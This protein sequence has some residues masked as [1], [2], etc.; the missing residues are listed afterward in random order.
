VKIA[1]VVL[2]FTQLMNLILVP[3]LAHAGLALS[4]G[5]G[6]LLNAAWLLIGL[7]RKGSFKPQPGWLKFGLR[8]VMA[9]LLLAIFLYLASQQLNWLVM[10]QQAVWRLGAMTLVMAFSVLIYFGTLWVSGLRLQSFLR[11]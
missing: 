9:T 1:I 5:L 4:I 11:R 8:V 10:R 7:L 2:C 3:Y 6:A